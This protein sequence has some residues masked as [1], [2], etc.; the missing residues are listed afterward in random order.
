M[1]CW[2]Y[3]LECKNGAQYTGVTQD[4]AVRYK[5]HSTGKGAKYTKMNGVDRIIYAIE[6]PTRSDACKLE[7]CLKKIGRAKRDAF[8][9]LNTVNYTA[10]DELGTKEYLE[11][12]LCLS[13]F[14]LG[15]KL[16]S[17]VV[18]LS[19]LKPIPAEVFSEELLKFS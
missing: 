15:E 8:L 17:S 12:M 3:I 4:L 16:Y 13:E 18:D 5:Q 10:M 14:K 7:R 6:L 9:Q 2:C 1:T 19:S 11:S